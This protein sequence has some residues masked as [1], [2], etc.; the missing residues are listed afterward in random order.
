MDENSPGPLWEI[1]P[2]DDTPLS[3][4]W[5]ERTTKAVEAP[6]PRD[7]G[8]ELSPPPCAIISL[9]NGPERPFRRMFGINSSAGEWKACAGYRFF[10]AL[11]FSGLPVYVAIKVDASVVLEKRCLSAVRVAN[12]ETRMRP[13]AYAQ[14]DRF[15]S[16]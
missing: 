15:H 10:S 5:G 8:G 13:S 7:E 2:V 6:L 4:S 11:P 3:P 12:V 14:D 9:M 1:Q 16:A